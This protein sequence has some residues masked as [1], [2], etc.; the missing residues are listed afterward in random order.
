MCGGSFSAF[1]GKNN[2]SMNKCLCV[3]ASHDVVTV[4]KTSVSLGQVACLPTECRCN[5][6]QSVFRKECV[7]KIFELE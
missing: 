1:N 3:T 7:R 5:A 2:K 6:G 4:C